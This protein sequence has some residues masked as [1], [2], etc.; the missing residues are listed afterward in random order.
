LRIP[1]GRVADA[2]ADAQA[3]MARPAVSASAAYRVTALLK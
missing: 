2:G 1:F 3:M